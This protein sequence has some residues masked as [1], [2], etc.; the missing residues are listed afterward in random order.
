MYHDILQHTYTYITYISLILMQHM[1]MYHDSM[2]LVVTTL[3]FSK[4]IGLK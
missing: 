3:Y 4:S 2:L 1:D